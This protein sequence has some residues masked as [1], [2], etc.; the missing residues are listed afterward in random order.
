MTDKEKHQMLFIQ[1][2]SSLQ[3]GALQQMGK[4]KNPATDTIERNLE[5]AEFTIDMLDMLREK[6]HGN[7]TPE[8]ERFLTTLV[9]ELKLNYVD[10]KAKDQKSQ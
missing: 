3:A 9:A 10:E 4:V 7:N 1:L 2:I 5:Q 6:T 8:E